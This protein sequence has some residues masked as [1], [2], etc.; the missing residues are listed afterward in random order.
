VVSTPTPQRA[1]RAHRVQ[2]STRVVNSAEHQ[3]WLA[4]HLTQRDRWLTRMV[5]EHKVL[6]THQIVELC[7]PT[8][9]TANLRLRN[10]RDW[11]VLHRFQPHR[12]LGSHP[13]HYV[14]DSAGATLLAHE[15]GIEPAKIGYSRQREIG[16]AHSLQLAH[17]VGCN[18]LLA[19]LV[20]RARQPGSTSRLASW[21]SAPRCAHH[22][23]DILTPDAYGRWEEHGNAVEFFVEFDF[24]TEQLSRLAAKLGRY[25]QLAT[26]TGITTPVLIWLPTAAR[27]ANARRAL[28]N[29]LL[30][31]DQPQL[32][33]VATTSGQT[34]PD[35]L[36]MAQPRWR[37]IDTP[38][39]G[40]RAT[41]TEIPAL[42]PHLPPPNR[43][44]AAPSV[45][46]RPTAE[47]TPPTPMPP[48][49]QPRR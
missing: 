47:I 23:G 22:W 46:S 35:P 10:L 38:Q 9:R 13:M 6:T 26:S 17:T 30:S 8:R 4:R 31:L 7:F 18:G 2:K 15:D 48:A 39:P 49:A 3:A 34:V 33:P 20:Y 25:E 11:G 44:S 29:A 19:R 32:V 28:S 41:L 14:L 16:R 45:P 5:F 36:D 37:R 21:W 24:G 40:G 12:A 27:E 1:L 43:I 42:W